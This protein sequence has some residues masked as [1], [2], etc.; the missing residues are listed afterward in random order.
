MNL[1]GSR[2]SPDQP[3]KVDGTEYWVLS[4]PVSCRTDVAGPHVLHP[5]V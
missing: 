4:Q 2:I 3:G 5:K 1:R